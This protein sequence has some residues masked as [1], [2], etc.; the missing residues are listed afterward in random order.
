[1]DKNLDQYKTWFDEGKI[2][3]EEY[4]KLRGKILNLS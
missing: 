3:E 2:D 1:M 4:K